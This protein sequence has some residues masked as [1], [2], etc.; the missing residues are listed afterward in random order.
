MI[1]DHAAYARE[2][3]AVVHGLL[4]DAAL[5]AART[6]A[7]AICRGQRGAFDGIAD[8]AGN[9]QDLDVLRRYLCIHFPHKISPFLLHLARLP[10]AVDVLTTVIGPN[11][12]M[13]QSM[14]FIK[15]AGRPGQAWHQDETFIP[16]RDR[17]LTAIWIAL[18]DATVENGCLWVIP[19]SHRPGVLYPARD[20]DDARFD[21]TQEA[22]G[23][24]YHEEHAVPVEVPAGAAVV[25]N[26]YLLHRSL[27]NT[28]RHGMRR[29]LVHH[30]M[31]A[32][33]LLPWFPPAPGTTMGKHD[34]RD[35]VLIAGE[36]PYAFRG[37]DDVVQPHVRH[38]GDGGCAR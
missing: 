23:F 28:G 7:S 15:S 26:G 21:C 20:Q 32:E 33:S 31:S 6:E 29:A 4:D 25:F 30:Y 34:H 18:D 24:A 38:N 14:L 1:I 22:Y 13:M 3:Y 5:E 11:V 37:T 8:S 12:K 36:D 19:G 9:E 35:I 2:G 16:T 27:P 17:S 10:A